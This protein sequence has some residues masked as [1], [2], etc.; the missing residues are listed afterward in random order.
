M[1][2]QL[3]IHAFPHRTGG[4][5]GGTSSAGEKRAAFADPLDQPAWKG[6]SWV[7]PV[8]TAVTGGTRPRPKRPSG[9]PRPQPA[10]F[11]TRSPLRMR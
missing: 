2:D 8:L 1:R 6:L 4:A 11:Y 5:P 3:V 9:T 10:R 7:V